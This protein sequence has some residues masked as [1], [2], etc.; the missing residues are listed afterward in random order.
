MKT[1]NDVNNFVRSSTKGSVRDFA[2][3]IVTVSVW[4]SVKNSVHDFVRGSLSISVWVS[5]LNKVQE[6]SK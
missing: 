2:M 6:L 1:L 5:A 3:T 4:N